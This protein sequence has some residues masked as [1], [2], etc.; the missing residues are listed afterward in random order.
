VRF[1]QVTGTGD[2]P[3]GSQEISRDGVI[4]RYAPDGRKLMSDRG[5]IVPG[6]IFRSAALVDAARTGRSVDL[7]E[8]TLDG[9]PA[10]ALSWEEPSPPLHH[11]KIELTLWVDRETYVPLQF[12]DHS[13]GLDAKGKPFDQTL[14]ETVNDF[15][16]LPDTPENRQL[17]EVNAPR[18]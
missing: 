5:R 14:T 12:T 15:K 1:L 13:Y 6:D 2:S 10:Y 9:R 7:E 3:A 16:R 4:T 11:P 17:L 8:T 18:D